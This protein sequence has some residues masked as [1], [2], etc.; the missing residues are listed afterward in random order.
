MDTYTAQVRRAESVWLVY[1]PEVDRTTQA[2]NVAE[3][4][5][6]AR[7]LVAVMRDVEPGSFE[8]RTE[9]E[10]PA[11]VRAHLDAVEQARAVEAE[12]R[13][14]GASELRAAATDLKHAGMSLR[15]VGALL[16]VSHQRASQLTAEPRTTRQP[17][18]SHE[19][20]RAAS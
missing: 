12:A 16:G 13:E 7:D 18:P 4:E 15:E 8:L 14:R 11:S 17:H 3:I 19:R 20:D 6:M 5:P 1:V 2:R 9:I 10:L